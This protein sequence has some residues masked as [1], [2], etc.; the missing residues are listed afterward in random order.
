MSVST[1]Y[2]QI[3]R[4]PR[5]KL[6]HAPTTHLILYMNA[7]GGSIVF[8]DAV[9]EIK[10]GGIF[11]IAK[12]CYHYTVPAHPKTYVR[13]K[14]ACSDEV[15]FQT[16]ELLKERLV[17]KAPVHR[18]TELSVVHAQIPDAMQAEVDTLFS[19]PSV[20]K[21]AHAQCLYIGN[22]LKILTYIDAYAIETKPRPVGFIAQAIRYISEHIRE[23]ITIEQICTEVRI[24]KYH[25]CREFK[26]VMKVTIMEYILKTRLI[27]S[28]NML[29]NENLSVG[30]ISEAC[31]FSSIS[32]FSATFK[33][34]TGK[35]PLRYRKENRT[36]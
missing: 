17:D 23:N 16:T 33:K 6:W 21:E 3:G 1:I 12:G 31:G 10:K 34:H 9:Y 19:T 18:F 15:L 14:M 11:F 25:L 8:D 13:S 30:E 32:Y 36:H 4:D 27:L 35:T 26:K 7:D 20:D 2:R 22:L 28:E 5:Y 29:V 24:S